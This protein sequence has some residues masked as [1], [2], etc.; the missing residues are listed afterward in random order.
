MVDDWRSAFDWKE[1]YLYHVRLFR[2]VLFWCC[3]RE[4]EGREVMVDRNGWIERWR[5]GV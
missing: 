4:A 5:G 2:P 1:A 3:I